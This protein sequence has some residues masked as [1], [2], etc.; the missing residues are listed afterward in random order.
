MKV[1]VYSRKAARMAAGFV[2]LT[3]TGLFAGTPA[4]RA[5]AKFESISEQRIAPGSA[6]SF[7]REEVSAWMVEEQRRT[8]SGIRN[9]AVSFGDGLVNFDCIVNLVELSASFNQP[10]DPISALFVQGE[11]AL[12][13]GLAVNSAG[14]RARVSLVA[15]DYDGGPAPPIIR[16]RMVGSFLAAYPA[17]KLNQSFA[18]SYNVDEVRVDESGIRVSIV[19]RARAVDGATTSNA[20]APKP[21]RPVA[22]SNRE[23]RPNS[24]SA[25]ARS[26][27]ASS[28]APENN[29]APSPVAGPSEQELNDA[30]ETLM[31]LQARAEAVYQALA[32]L[33]R[34]QH[35]AGFG[36][37]G[38]IVASRS[39][40]SSYLRIARTQIQERNLTGIQHRFDAAEEE[41]EK[42]E[43]FLGR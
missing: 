1:E 37:R 5:R 43:K 30:S 24:S 19:P 40:L 17:V 39:R 14:G 33:E 7:S 22:A 11:H 27:D 26:G 38:D 4:D 12:R 15:F 2:F 9:L 6:V 29:P 20:A 8:V 28:A 21:I 23:T 31:K 3:C 13:V 10:L 42:L 41:V 36:L 18:L 32:D 35:A 16:E 25:P 34:Q